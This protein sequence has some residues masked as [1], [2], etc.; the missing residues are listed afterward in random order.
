MIHHNKSKAMLEM[1]TEGKVYKIGS[2]NQ[3]FWT[4]I[5]QKNYDIEAE[6]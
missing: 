6:K 2:K 4:N 3:Q 1:L 5:I